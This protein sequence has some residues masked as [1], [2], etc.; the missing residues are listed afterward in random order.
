MRD[1]DLSIV[2][3]IVG[4]DVNLA[5]F[6]KDEQHKKLEIVMQQRREKVEKWR[7][8]QANKKKTELFENQILE[9]TAIKED[10]S[11]KKWSLEDDSDE[12]D[13]GEYNLKHDSIDVDDSKLILPTKRKKEDD[14]E[15]MFNRKLAKTS[16]NQFMKIETVKP[17]DDR[18]DVDP[19]DL[20]MEGIE[21]EMKKTR[22]NVI[23]KQEKVLNDKKISIITGVAKKKQAQETVQVNKGELLEQNQDALEYSSEDETTDNLHQ[24]NSNLM[25][26]SKT[27][28]LTSISKD[29]I[30]FMPFEKCFY[31][32][33][34]ELA[35]MT[36]EE[37]EK[38]REELEGIKVRGKG[39]PKP[40]KSWSHCGVSKRVFECLKRYNYKQPT[41]IQAQA[42]PAIMSGRDI[43]G[44]AKTGSGKTLAFLLPMFRHVLAQPPLNPGDGP[45][46]II[47]TPTRELAT[48]I[49]SECR[50]F[51]KYIGL[52]VVTVYGGTPISE[53]I[54]ELKSG[55][56]I[57]VCTPGRM[58]DML[59]SNSGRVINLRR[60]TYLVIDEAGTFL[61]CLSNLFFICFLILFFFFHRPYVRPWFRSTSE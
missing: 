29:D 43:I 58:I 8:E 59:A 45:I 52:K 42:I 7:M 56:E 34:A 31:V 18:D 53:Q 47:M 4:A 11:A 55:A 30:T 6:D 21:N 33:V 54:G 57:V 1:N 49:T 12:N 36:Q 37:V 13:S 14:G 9:Q 28:K 25:S 24:L 61:I 15:F 60:C 51:T 16:S 23:K 48:Q 26:T 22:G 27:K 35:K 20:Y 3:D 17:P 41:P 32:E 10:K 50:K 44:I 39:C 38:L 46:A 2:E 5:S 19:L 40:V